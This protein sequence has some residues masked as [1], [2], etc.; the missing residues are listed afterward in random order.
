MSYIL[1]DY[2]LST[3]LVK[4]III[5]YKYVIYS[6]NITNKYVYIRFL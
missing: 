1:Y 4:L 5:S 6:E 3:L 2:F